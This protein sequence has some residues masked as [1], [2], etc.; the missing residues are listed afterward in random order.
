MDA[1]GLEVLGEFGDLGGGEQC[2]GD[3]LAAD[4]RERT[5]VGDG[6][7]EPDVPERPVI[8]AIPRPVDRNTR[9]PFAR[10]ARIAATAEGGM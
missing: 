6:A 1:P 3:D 8:S 7:V 5:A 2:A 9:C 10:A 4:A